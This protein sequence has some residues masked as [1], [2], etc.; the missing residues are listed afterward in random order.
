MFTPTDGSN[1]CEE[2]EKKDTTEP[3]KAQATRKYLG[4]D[5]EWKTEPI[6]EGYT[7]SLKAA[8]ENA[9]ILNRKEMANKM[10]IN[11]A[12]YGNYEFKNYLPHQFLSKLCEIVNLP[13]SA[14]SCREP[15]RP[16]GHTA[17]NKNKIQENGLAQPVT[18]KI[19]PE[20]SMFKYAQDEENNEYRY[21][22]SQWL[23][24]IATGLT[25]GAKKHPNK[26]WRDIPIDEHLSRALRHINLA[27][28]GDV[29][30]P[31]IINAS[32]RLMM[33]YTLI[34]YRQK[35]IDFGK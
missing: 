23:D 17:N 27:R 30:E 7:F 8:R 18:A 1:Y 14:I 6:P 16:F 10:G 5:G 12:S 28:T 29:S 22:D 31:H 11:P 15:L 25:A 21:I 35:Y 13:E 34:R 4:P 20:E 26:T 24:A 9:G 3:E 2:C 32:M 33:A 19:A